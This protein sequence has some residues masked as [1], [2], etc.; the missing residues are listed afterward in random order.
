MKKTFFFCLVLIV[1]GAIMFCIPVGGAQWDFEILDSERLEECVYRSGE[2]ESVQAE[3]VRKVSL[4]LE[5]TQFKLTRSGEEFSLR[6]YESEFYTF[7]IGAADGTLTFR[8][9]RGGW[10][11]WLL[12][13]HGFKRAKRTTEL[14]I[15]ESFEGE[16]EIRC[17]NGALCLEGGTYQSLK[18]TTV[19]G[20]IEISDLSAPQT[21]I[22]T[23]NGEISL[24][25]VSAGQIDLRTTNG[26][27]EG[28]GIQA[29]TLAGGT[30]N[31][32]VSIS[33]IQVESADCSSVN[34]DVR[35]RGRAD[36]VSA[37]TTNGDVEIT[38][39]GERAD[40]EIDGATA[41]KAFAGNQPGNGSGKRV[42]LRTTNG[43]LSLS[44]E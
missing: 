3:T 26:R 44:I 43:D 35:I 40:Y 25:N 21:E 37:K 7:E 33:E 22:R 9:K 1:A 17:V 23:T 6:Y 16:L 31:G 32:T 8:E 13:F 20:A 19:N 29:E 18:L 14:T 5:S 30:T 39:A 42:Y 27:V 15:P 11:N 34:G 12:L 24:R 4:S 36:R 28:S 10:Q 41:R 38:L 2:D